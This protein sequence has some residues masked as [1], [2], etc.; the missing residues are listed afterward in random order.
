MAHFGKAEQQ[1]PLDRDDLDAYGEAAWWSGR[2][3]DA[4]AIRERAFAA[5]Q[6]AGD[7]NRAA[8]AGLSLVGHYQNANGASVASGWTRRV[9][10]LLADRPES[11]EH[12]GLERVRLNAALHHGDLEGALAAAERIVAIAQRLNDRDL[13]VVGL[14]DLGR[15]LIA[16]GRVAEGLDLLD[17]AVVAA[18][19]GEVSRYN[20]ALVYCNATIACEDLTDYRRAREFAEVAE[21]WC[22]QQSISGFP[23]MCRVRRVELLRLRG[24]WLEA[25]SEARRACLELTD[26]SVSFEAEGFY[27]I[28]EIR[29]RMNDLPEAEAA[30]THAH[31]LGREPLP[32]LALVRLAQGKEDAAGT[33][34]ARALEGSSL[35]PLERA[36]LLP[37]EVEVA[38]ALRDLGRA[39]RAA[40]ELEGIAAKYATDILR[41]EADY[42]RG[43]VALAGGADEVAVSALRRAVRTWQS[44]DTPFEAA[45]ARMKLGEA[46]RATGDAESARL[47]FEAAA[48]SLEALG[49]AGELGRLRALMADVPRT[50]TARRTRH[51]TR[52]FMFT[53]IVGSTGLIEAV[54]D[55]AWRR[56]QAWHDETIRELLRKHDGQ[57]IHHAGDGFFVAFESADNGIVCGIAIRDTLLRHRDQH[58]FAPSVRIGLHTAEAVKTASSYE[59][60]GVH[61]AARI[62]AL[63]VGDQVLASRATIEAAGR[64]VAHDEYRAEHLRGIRRPVEVAV[65]SGVVGQGSTTD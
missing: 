48:V 54:G 26:F 39:E 7:V 27:Q 5:H 47:E 33:L 43:L 56:L 57:E 51:A 53:D 11:K 9:E 45:R 31:R 15:V 21:R 4:I 52:T 19:S 30:F 3:R 20:T 55:D 46:Y 28:G 49:A 38:L 22:A 60:A 1:G 61:V 42:A 2:L 25:E 36:R 29:V 24:A 35:M 64:P 13:E 23:G 12:G 16:L 37:A 14:Q 59:G 8:A 65:V 58:G 32:G 18:V 17:E 10:R 40:A 62:G 41:A 34:L 50:A 44:N 6:A 63:A